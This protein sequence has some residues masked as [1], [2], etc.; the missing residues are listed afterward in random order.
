MIMHENGPGAPLYAT[1]HQRLLQH[2]GELEKLQS[3]W[4]SYGAI[5]IEDAA[6]ANAVAFVTM[7]LPRLDAPVPPPVV[8]PTP[9]GGVVLRW[10]TSEG[11]VMVKLL[12]L[13]GEYYVAKRGADEVLEEGAVG[14]L[15]SLANA[16]ARSL[17][18][19]C[20]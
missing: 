12:S 6:R 19:L 2:I 7:L 11:E 3:G 15:E 5:K 16:I 17:R 14:S 8:G 9:D 20:C 13:G 4:D 1:A 10:E 18:S